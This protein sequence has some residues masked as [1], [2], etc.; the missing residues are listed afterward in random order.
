MNPT[1]QAGLEPYAIGEKLRRLRL[2]KSMGLT[3]LGKHTGLSPAML[4]KLERGRVFPTLPTLLRIAMVFSVG[5]EYFFT[6]PRKRHVVAVV[7]R[8]ERLRFPESMDARQPSYTFESLDFP[9]VDRKLNAYLAEFHKLAAEK[10]R[11]HQHPGV[12][13]L[14]LISGKLEIR[15]DSRTEVLET[16]DSIYFDSSVL[17][18]YRRLSPRRCSA[19]V[20]TT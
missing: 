8:R 14:Y 20:V 3:Q 15:I 7:R 1:I 9:A 6:D 17:H 10:V 12:E 5:L 13:L 4:S 11:P 18:S 2:K 19:V 16:G